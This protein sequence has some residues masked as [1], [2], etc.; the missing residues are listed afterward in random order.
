MLTI[1]S[2]AML[3]FVLLCCVVLRC[4]GSGCATLCDRFGLWRQTWNEC[5][6]FSEKLPPGKRG[7]PITSRH[8]VHN[9]NNRT[10]PHHLTVKTLI[11][12]F[13]AIV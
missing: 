11:D 12:G 5:D 1:R 9:K 8:I 2:D 10:A 6:E 3:C 13:T 4:V 7:I